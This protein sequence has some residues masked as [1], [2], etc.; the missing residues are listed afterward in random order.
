MKKRKE[1][2]FSGSLLALVCVTGAAAIINGADWLRT[3][4]FSGCCATGVLLGRRIRQGKEQR[5]EE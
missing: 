1:L 2:S 3:L 4:V 5:E